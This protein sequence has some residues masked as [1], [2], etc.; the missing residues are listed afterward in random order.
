MAFITVGRTS[1]MREEANDSSVRE[2]GDV[3]H[4]T[5][6][7]SSRAVIQAR[8]HSFWSQPRVTGAINMMSEKQATNQESSGA[9]KANQILTGER[10]QVVP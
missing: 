1:H 2:V 6:A 9:W 7:V 10:H 4:M 8:W 3:V 5:S